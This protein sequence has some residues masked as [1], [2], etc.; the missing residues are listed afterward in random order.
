MMMSSTM[1]TE[2]QCDQPAAFAVVAGGWGGGRRG[3]KEEVSV[4]PL[5]STCSLSLSYSFFI[6]EI[7]AICFVFCFFQMSPTK[8]LNLQKLFHSIAMDLI[9]D[10]IFCLFCCCTRGNVQV[11][12]SCLTLVQRSSCQQLLI[13]GWNNSPS[14]SRD[15][16]LKN[17]SVWLACAQL[18]RETPQWNTRGRIWT[19]HQRAGFCS[20]PLLAQRS[21]KQTQDRW[22]G[23]S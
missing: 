13:T 16:I 17:A 5:T 1:V 10:M 14:R 8:F 12:Q 23:F 20:F 19:R 18:R 6:I 21:V 11:Q 4:T 9:C 22:M 15:F 3:S 7:K 2:H